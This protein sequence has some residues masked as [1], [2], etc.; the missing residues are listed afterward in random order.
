M[1]QDEDGHCIWYGECYK[2]EKGKIKNCYNTTDPVKLDNS[3]GLE[4]LGRRCPY[5]YNG[6][7]KFQTALCIFFHCYTVQ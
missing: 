3:E 2:D 4:I 6:I 1:S 7:G 5:I